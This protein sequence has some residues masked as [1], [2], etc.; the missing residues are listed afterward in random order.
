MVIMRY[1][2]VFAISPFY[3]VATDGEN[4]QN[5]QLPGLNS[6]NLDSGGKQLFSLY[7]VYFLFTITKH[8]FR[9]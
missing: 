7:F 2:N 8:Y 4:K 3:Y 1:M 5:G 9:M 6:F